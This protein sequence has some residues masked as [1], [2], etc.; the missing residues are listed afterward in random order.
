MTARNS[1]QGA[2]MLR[3]DGET[4]VGFENRILPT[5]KVAKLIG[6]LIM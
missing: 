2:V 4:F 5:G 1:T 3:L 6:A